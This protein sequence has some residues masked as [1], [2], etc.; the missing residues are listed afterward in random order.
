MAIAGVTAQ[1]LI[2]RTQ[3]EV[4]ERI[5]AKLRQE[6]PG[7]D[8]SEGPEHQIAE[9]VAEEIGEQWEAL[10]AVFSVQGK[11]AA[12]LA[13]DQVS[14]LTGTERRAATRST[15]LATVT[16]AA[17][18]TLEAGAV[19]AVA[20][21]P[22]AQFRTTETVTNGGGA[23][24]DIDVT[25]EAVQTGP[26]AAPADSLTAIVTPRAGWS[27]VTNAA[28]ASL[29]RV[30]AGDVELRAQRRVELAGAGLRSYAAI[31]AALSEL[32]GV[33]AVAVRYNETL[34]TDVDGRP[35]KSFE[36]I[37]W[38][39]SPPPSAVANL[40]AQAVWD[41]KPEGIA[42]WGVGSTVGTAVDADTGES[43][44]IEYTAATALPVHV[45]LEVVLDGA[46]G[47]EWQTQVKAAIVAR[48]AEYSVGDRVYAS[49]LIAAVLDDVAGVEA[50]TDL[51]VGTAPS[52]SAS[53]VT[54]AYYEV[55]SI[56]AGN[57]T[58]TV[59]P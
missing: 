32:E 9:I 2:I 58:I 55:P 33:I 12:G 17:G 7:I 25:M 13:L 5:K 30:V 50:V 31:R 49:Q 59:A 3:A 19:A 6:F 44:S 4:L 8:L 15:V 20:A 45:D 34:I 57:I 24:A 29:G 11:D 18:A 47:D 38:A 39:G 27:A 23:P 14:A 26:V 54:P 21:D 56:V 46:Q 43:K 53:L 35:A 42:S 41:H 52:P 22:D 36:P 51:D 10:A 40:V 37:V 16:L 48:A 28:D 1:G